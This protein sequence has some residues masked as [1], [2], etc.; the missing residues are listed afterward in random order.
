VGIVNGSVVQITAGS[1][2]E[3]DQNW[4]QDHPEWVTEGPQ[5]ALYVI[6][7]YNGLKAV[8]YPA[9]TRNGDIH[10]VAACGST[11]VLQSTG[12]TIFTFDV[13]TMTYVSNSDSCSAPTP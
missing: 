11:L 10:I 2:I 6:L 9:P 12:N 8:K 1:L 5:G 7:D 13:T 4:R 3:T